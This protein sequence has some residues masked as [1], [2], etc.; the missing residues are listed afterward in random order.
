MSVGPVRLC[1]SPPWLPGPGPFPGSRLSPHKTGVGECLGFSSV[2][3]ACTGQGR[4]EAGPTPASFPAR[5]LLSPE[6]QVVLAR[7]SWTL[8]SPPPPPW[9]LH[10]PGHRGPQAPHLSSFSK[11]D[12]SARLPSTPGWKGDLGD[13]DWGVQLGVSPGLSTSGLLCS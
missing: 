5:W 9:A 3:E 1:L 11:P 7:S 13:L 10:S 6:Y 8:S 4:T 2:A 12:G